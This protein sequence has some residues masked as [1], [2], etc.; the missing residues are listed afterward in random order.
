MQKKAARWHQDPADQAFEAAPG[1]G[2]EDAGAAGAGED[3]ADA[4]GV[5]DAEAPSIDVD[6]VP[7]D[8][9]SDSPPPFFT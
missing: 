1:E 6:S 4:A 2:E 7:L 5:E 8:F 9:P 3:E